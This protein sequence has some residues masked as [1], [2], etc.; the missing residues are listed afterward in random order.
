MEAKRLPGKEIGVGMAVEAFRL[1][2][3][4]ILVE[5]KRLPGEEIGGEMT[6]EA[7]RLPVRGNM[8]EVVHLP[9]TEREIQG[10]ATVRRRL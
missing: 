7:V 4:E 6:V 10:L 1:P 8:V 3:R 2:V 5:V 9:K